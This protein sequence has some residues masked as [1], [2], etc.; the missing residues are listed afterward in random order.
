MYFCKLVY[1]LVFASNILIAQSVKPQSLCFS[2]RLLPIMQNSSDKPEISVSSSYLESI[3]NNNDK[4]IKK[5]ESV[6][7]NIVKYLKSEKDD[8]ETHKMEKGFVS[9]F[10]PIPKANFDTIFLSIFQICTVYMSYNLDRII[11]ELQSGKRYVYYIK[12]KADYKKI[13]QLID[14]IPNKIKHVII[15]D[16]KNTMDDVFGHLYCEPK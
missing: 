5:L 8:P 2:M 4:K 14:L 7:N 11:F 3:N 16:V 10:Y 12:D 15:N 13:S 9:T 1:Y 6:R